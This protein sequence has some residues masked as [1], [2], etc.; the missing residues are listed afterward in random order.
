MARVLI[1]PQL[2][3]VTPAAKTF[4]A[5]PAGDGASINLGQDAYLGLRNTTGSPIVATMLTVVTIDGLTLPNKPIT[6]APNITLYFK[7]LTL[8]LYEQADGRMYIDCPST[9]LSIAVLTLG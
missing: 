4:T 8:D 6:I 1:E 7:G 5:I 3:T 2:V 9:G